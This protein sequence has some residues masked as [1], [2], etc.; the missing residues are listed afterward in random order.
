[1]KKMMCLV[2]LVGVVFVMG[3][4]QV[5]CCEKDTLQCEAAEKAILET[6]SALIAAAENRDIET[7]FSYILENDKGAIVQDGQLMSRQ[8]ALEQIRR[9]F[10]RVTDINY[11]FKQRSIK[12]LSPKIALLTAIGTTTSTIDTGETFTSEFAN[13]SVFVLQDDG[14]KIIHGHH[15]IP[16]P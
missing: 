6:H 10:E 1:M 7:M 12:M 9:G 15:S 8:E 14:W 2:A 5:P 4:Q 16:N 11:D 3:C 13:T